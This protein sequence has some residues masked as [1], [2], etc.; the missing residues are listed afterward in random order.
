[1]E[2]VSKKQKTFGD[3]LGEKYGFPASI[4]QQSATNLATN[5][6]GPM[7]TGLGDTS[8]NGDNDFLTYF[9]TA[10]DDLDP[11]GFNTVLGSDQPW[12]FAMGL[13]DETSKTPAVEEVPELTPDGGASNAGQGAE[14]ELSIEQE[15]Q[16]FWSSLGMDGVP[17]PSALTGVDDMWAEFIQEEPSDAGS[18]K[19]SQR[20]LRDMSFEE[21]TG[22]MG[23]R[24]MDGSMLFSGTVV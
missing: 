3:N 5:T 18:E 16:K 7:Q 4:E 19:P 20:R 17:L 12:D 8:A 10:L 13:D 22:F 2:S 1:M 15:N 9:R 23:D 21:I 11:Y 14:V 6:G 24:V